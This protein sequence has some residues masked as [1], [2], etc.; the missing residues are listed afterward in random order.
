M[1]AYWLHPVMVQR[2]GGAYGMGVGVLV[3][4]GAGGVFV[5][6]ARGCVVGRPGGVF[7]SVVVWCP[8]ACAVV[9]EEPCAAGVVDGLPMLGVDAGGDEVTLVAGC[10]PVLLDVVVAGPAEGEEVA[11]PVC[12]RGVGSAHAA[13]DAVVDVMRA[14]LSA[15]LALVVVAAT[16]RGLGDL[17]GVGVEV[18][19]VDAV[20]ACC[21]A[22]ADPP[23]DD[24][25]GGGVEAVVVVAHSCSRE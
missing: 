17:P 3:C 2:E 22:G 15:P 23:G 4:E 24:V 9:V 18:A 21:A 11:G 16:D 19:G 10:G 6:G 5:W 7:F 8:G 13:G 12:V 20:V 25:V 1:T 14:V